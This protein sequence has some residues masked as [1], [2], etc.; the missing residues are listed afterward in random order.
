MVLFTTIPKGFF[1][2]EDIGQIQV[3]TEAAEDISFPAMMALQD[4][5]ADAIQ[6]DPACRT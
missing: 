5:V 4:H 3:T 6:A 2:E 1:P